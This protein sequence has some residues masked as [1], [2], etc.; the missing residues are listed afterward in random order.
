MTPKEFCYWLQGFFEMANPKELTPEQTEMVKKHLTLVFI[1]ITNPAQPPAF[2]STK[3][4]EEWYKN[5]LT[6][7]CKAIS[8]C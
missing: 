7:D 2:E 6:T 3:D 8:Y 5:I 4:L 1:N